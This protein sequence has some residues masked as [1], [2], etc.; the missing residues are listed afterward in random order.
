[1]VSLSK[2]EPR[3]LSVGILRL[4]PGV[5]LSEAKNLKPQTL[6]GA[7]GDK[8]RLRSHGAGNI[9]S[10]VVRLSNLGQMSKRAQD[11]APDPPRPGPVALLRGAEPEEVVL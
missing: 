8:M 10:F 1:M 11:D 7:Q 6:R 5:I 3:A 4:L 2:D 9:Q